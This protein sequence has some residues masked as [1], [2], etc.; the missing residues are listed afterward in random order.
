MCHP[1][2]IRSSP[3]PTDLTRESSSPAAA[4]L[5]VLIELVTLVQERPSPWFSQPQVCLFFTFD[6]SSSSKMAFLGLG[7]GGGRGLSSGR[8]GSCFTIPGREKRNSCHLATRKTQAGT[9]CGVQI[10]RGRKW[11]THSTVLQNS[12]TGLFNIGFKFHRQ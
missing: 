5:F 10:R 4:Y 1:A 3:N 2:E 8:A 7:G 9:S 6:F 11:Q 12:K